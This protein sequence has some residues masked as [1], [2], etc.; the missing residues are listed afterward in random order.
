[1][2]RTTELSSLA[3]L[4]NLAAV[5]G[6]IGIGENHALESLNLTSLRSIGDSL[7]AW[8]N[9]QLCPS[10]LNQLQYVTGVSDSTESGNGTGHDNCPWAPDADSIAPRHLSFG[11]T[12]GG[13]RPV[14]HRFRSAEVQGVFKSWS[15][16]GALPR[17]GSVE[18]G[19]SKGT[20]L[21]AYN[22]GRNR[23][24]R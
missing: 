18:W 23:I 3:D 1:M 11:T 14:S 22:A 10:E 21:D 24:L 7:E 6:Y 19:L 9:P 17:P 20:L 12:D 4:G 13:C 16:S 15:R 2:W 5:D 8:D